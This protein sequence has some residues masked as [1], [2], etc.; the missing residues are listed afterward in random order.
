[1]SNE[2]EE[3]V[4]GITFWFK[5]SSVSAAVAEGEKFRAEL[6]LTCGVVDEELW[7]EV[8]KRFRE[9]FRVFSSNDFHIEVLSVMNQKVKT[10]EREKQDLELSLRRAEARILSVTQ[11]FEAYKA[12]LQALGTALRRPGGGG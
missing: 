6:K 11:E 7:N 10:L 12:P 2:H 1:V 8:L 5:H 3:Q 9:G 4:A